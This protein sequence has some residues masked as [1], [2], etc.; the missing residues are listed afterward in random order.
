MPGLDYQDQTDFSRGMVDSAALTAYPRNAGQLL[1]NARIQPNGRPRRRKGSRRKHA[2]AQSETTPYGAITFTTAAGTVQEI[3]FFG[4]EAYMSDDGWASQSTIAT[5]L[6]QDYY[7]FAIM[8][9]GSTNY[10][11]AAN[12]DTTVKRWDGSTWDTLPNAPSGAR[13]IEVFNRRLWV[14]DDTVFPKASASCFKPH[15]S[16]ATS[17]RT[18][19]MAESS[20]VS[21]SSSWMSPDTE[22]PS[23]RYTMPSYLFRGRWLKEMSRV[24]SI[25][26]R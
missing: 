1:E 17:D 24:R 20:F 15:V 4:D 25:S 6:R 18:A 12:G 19:G 22:S 21:R 14:T 26:R 13:R 10:L 7:D 8:R 16:D 9:V 5:S 23:R 3:A 2:S 11:F